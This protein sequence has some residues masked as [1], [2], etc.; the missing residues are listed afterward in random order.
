[1]S[2]AG[3]LVSVDEVLQSQVGVVGR[4]SKVRRVQLDETNRSHNPKVGGSNPPPALHGIAGRRVCRIGHSGLA[5]R[6]AFE[7]TAA[8]RVY[9]GFFSGPTHSLR[10]LPH[11][12]RRRARAPRPATSQSSRRM[13]RGCMWQHR[14]CLRQLHHSNV[15]GGRAKLRSR[16][17]TKAHWFEFLRAHAHSGRRQGGPT[18]TGRNPRAAGRHGQA[19]AGPTGGGAARGGAGGAGER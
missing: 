18:R 16:C 3:S 4:T 8:D 2:E 19:A 11:A 6:F 13:A 12:T 9:R 15:V 14:A 10:T 5:S 7:A 17:S 1:M